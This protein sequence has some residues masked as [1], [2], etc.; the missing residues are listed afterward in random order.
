VPCFS[1]TAADKITCKHNPNLVVTASTKEEVCNNQWNNFVAIPKS[2]YKKGD[3]TGWEFKPKVEQPQFDAGKQW[4]LATATAGWANSFLGFLVQDYWVRGKKD[5]GDC[6]S[7]IQ[8]G[9]KCDEHR[10][11]CMGWLKPEHFIQRN[12]KITKWTACA[13]GSCKS[14]KTCQVV[15]LESVKRDGFGAALVA[16]LQHRCAVRCGMA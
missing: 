16:C 8:G 7:N 9:E 11:L 1:A 3:V 2:G 13:H 10:G 12:C 5:V 6:R 4:A 14:K 15:D